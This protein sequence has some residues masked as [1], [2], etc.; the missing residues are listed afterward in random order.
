MGSGQSLPTTQPI[1]S[2]PVPMAQQAAPATQSNAIMPMS[3]K[4]CVSDKGVRVGA[5]SLAECERH[6]RQS[7]TS[8]SWTE[9]IDGKVISEDKWLVEHECLDPNGASLGMVMNRGECQML[10]A[11]KQ[12][13]GRYIVKFDGNEISSLS[14]DPPRTAAPADASV[15]T[16]TA[17]QATSVADTSTLSVKTKKE[18]EV[19]GQA[20]KDLWEL[21]QAFHSKTQSDWKNTNTSDFYSSSAFYQTTNDMYSR[22]LLNDIKNIS[23]KYQVLM[24]AAATES[25]SQPDLGTVAGWSVFWILLLLILCIVLAV[26]FKVPAQ[27]FKSARVDAK[28]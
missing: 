11:S 4:I 24:K 9:T 15:T 5:E 20:S 23:Q 18:I 8:G 7:L 26:Y 16:A 21:L 3:T 1:L 14:Y 25:F 10:V 19:M 17:T 22:Q 27:L 13:K 6:F 12:T 28:V 2:M